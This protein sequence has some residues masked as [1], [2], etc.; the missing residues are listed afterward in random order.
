MDATWKAMQASL[1]RSTQC[2]LYLIPD[3]SIEVQFFLEKENVV[4]WLLKTLT[5]LLR[6]A[7]KG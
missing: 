7:N 6:L 2:L 4:L 5:G 1:T 3:Y